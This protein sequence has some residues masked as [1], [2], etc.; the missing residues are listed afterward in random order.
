M[1]D[2][3][4]Y[5]QRLYL[6][7]Q[8]STQLEQPQWEELVKTGCHLS[9]QSKQSIEALLE[10]KFKIKTKAWPRWF[11]LGIFLVVMSILYIGW[12]IFTFPTSEK[13]TEIT[14][15][16]QAEVKQVIDNTN[17]LEQRATHTSVEK[18]DAN[19]RY[20]SF[21]DSQ[22]TQVQIT[23]VKINTNKSP[24]WVMQHEVSN[25]LYNACIR[26][27]K[28]R[29]NKVISTSL[30]K[31]NLNNDDYPAVQVSWYSIQEEFIPFL[32]AQLNTKFALP[33]KIQWLQISSQAK[34]DITNGKQNM[35]FQRDKMGDGGGGEIGEEGGEIGEE[36][37]EIGEEGG[38]IGEDGEK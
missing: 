26:A 29:D 32:N 33:S 35:L 18:L 9:G 28:C 34:I 37:G 30:K 13:P 38:E 31:Q 8:K 25:Q 1:S 2:Y 36:G 14:H 4:V 10:E 23:L 3:L 12:T 16:P 24:I 21:T 11:L 17:S 6:L 19:I 20:L 27:G 15:Q 7:E 5:C 22:N